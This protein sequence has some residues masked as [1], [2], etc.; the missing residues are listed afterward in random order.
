MSVTL[1]PITDIGE[2]S[3][4]KLGS[5]QANNNNSFEFSPMY[6]GPDQVTLLNAYN[7]TLWFLFLC[8][9]HI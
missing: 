9:S 5:G 4:R 3:F 2:F 7:I 1:L 6:I 8:R